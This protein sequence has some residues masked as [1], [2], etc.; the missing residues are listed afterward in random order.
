MREEIAYMQ[1]PFWKFIPVVWEKGVRLG[2]SFLIM[3]R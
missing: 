3:F 1:V 2:G